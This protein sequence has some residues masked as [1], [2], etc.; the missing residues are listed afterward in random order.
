[1]FL[2]DMGS[3]ASHHA[4]SPKT[5]GMTRKQLD[6]FLVREKAPIERLRAAYKKHKGNKNHIINNPFR[7]LH[8]FVEDGPN[9]HK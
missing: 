9:D 2:I 7:V 8:G 5:H 4:L 3:C 6:N 1:M